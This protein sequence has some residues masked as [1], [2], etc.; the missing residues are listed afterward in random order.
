MH[1]QVFQGVEL[2]NTHGFVELFGEKRVQH[3]KS[4]L[5]RCSAHRSVTAPI[6]TETNSIPKTRKLH[7]RASGRDLRQG[8]APGCAS[9]A[10]FGPAARLGAGGPSSTEACL[11]PLTVSH[12]TVFNLRNT[13]QM[14]TRFSISQNLEISSWSMFGRLSRT[15]ARRCGEDMKSS[16]RKSVALNLAR[17]AAKHCQFLQPHCKP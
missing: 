11:E 17:P 1:E 2:Q 15:F 6:Q 14:F 16:A 7:T 4:A 3:S 13:S 8:P 12:V 9:H 10:R 5:E